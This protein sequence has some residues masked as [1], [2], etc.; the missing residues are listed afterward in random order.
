[1]GLLICK[2]FGH[3]AVYSHASTRAFAEA[4]AATGIPAM[5]FDYAGTGDS[6]DLEPETDQLDCWLGDC[7]ASVKELQ[8]LTGVEHVCLLGL[9]LGGLLALQAAGRCSAVSALVLISPVIRGRKYFR[10]LRTT[11]LASI[12]GVKQENAS[13]ST[14]TESAASSG[15]D[16]EVAGF[17]L[18][19]ASIQTLS[20]VDLTG[21]ALPAPNALIIDGDTLPASRRWAEA[22]CANDPRTTYVALPGLIEMLMTPPDQGRIPAEMVLATRDWLA[23]HLVSLPPRSDDET[24]KQSDLPSAPASPL[25]RMADP[26][27]QSRECVTEK[28]TFFGAESTLFGVVTE[29]CASQKPTGAVIL[30]NAGGSYHV[31]ANRMYVPL[32]RQWARRGYVVL[33]MDYAGLGDSGIWQ[34]QAWNDIFPP[35]AIS[36]IRSGVEFVQKTYGISDVSLCGLCAGAYHALWAA[37]AALPIT[38]ALMVNPRWYWRDEKS[39]TDIVQA[40]LVRDTNTYSGKTFSMGTWRRLLS[41]QIDV[42]FVM[43]AYA[44]RLLA[45]LA[46]V[47]RDLARRLRIRLR[48]DLGWELEAIAARGIRLIFIFAPGEPGI[49][50][51][52]LQAGASL[53]RLGERCRIYIVDDG[54]HVFSKRVPRQ[55]LTEILSTELLPRPESATT[56]RT[57]RET[58]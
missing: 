29:P 45:M 54:D 11:N 27:H 56:L 8:R 58:G 13:D 32:A 1:M 53:R 20:K 52:N 43:K 18:S 46:G 9:R 42:R 40:E 44:N 14:G 39:D 41:G 31:G 24:R 25:L 47:T 3:E 26:R 5:R 48:R 21:L 49:N 33:R 36:D 55:A 16:L 2:P 6:S 12:L 22:L 50:L 17:S 35:S 57:V 34:G 37:A 23:R 30:L 19:A 15:G 4:A 28:P 10:E 51:L 38:R 7:L